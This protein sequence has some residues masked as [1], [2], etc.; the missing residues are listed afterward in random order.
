MAEE[1]GVGWKFI[2]HLGAGIVHLASKNIKRLANKV[3]VGI[4]DFMCLW[5]PVGNKSIVARN[6]HRCIRKVTPLGRINRD[7]LARNLTRSEGR[8]GAIGTNCSLG[9]IGNQLTEIAAD[10]PR[11][12]ILRQTLDGVGPHDRKSICSGA[13][14]VGV[15]LAV[16][17]AHPNGG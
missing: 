15:E 8:Q 16:V 5:V 10:R 11:I 7:Q 6:N 14:V 4:E 2:V 9:A 17:E 3:P 1:G 13:T 12:A